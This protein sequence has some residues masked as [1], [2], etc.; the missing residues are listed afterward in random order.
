MKSEQGLDTR[1]CTVL[2]CDQL[3]AKL[4]VFLPVSFEWLCFSFT[5]QIWMK[6]KFSISKAIPFPLSAIKNGH[7]C[8]VFSVLFIILHKRITRF[9]F[10]FINS[11]DGLFDCAFFHSFHYFHHLTCNTFIPHL[12]ETLVEI[13]F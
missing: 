12:V 8:L 2:L 4:E 5:L 11:L 10:F 7:A 3:A 9:L 6:L 1:W 13:R